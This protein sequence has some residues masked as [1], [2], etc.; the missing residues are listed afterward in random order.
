MTS[1]SFCAMAAEKIHEKM[2]FKRMMLRFMVVV[3]ICTRQI[4]AAR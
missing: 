2:K 3:L 1:K 4:Y